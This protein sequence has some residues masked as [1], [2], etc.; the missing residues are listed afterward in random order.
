MN[1]IDRLT[2]ILL[3]LQGGKRSASQIARRFEISR[4][5][6]Q[7]DVQALSEM[8]IPVIADFGS[9]GGY[10]LPPD[11]ALPP[12]ALTLHEALLLRLALSGISQLGETLLKQE[13]ASLLDKIETLLPRAQTPS[14]EQL[15]EAISLHE[16]AR[17]YPTPFLDLLL[18]SAAR[19]QWVRVSYRSERGLSNQTLLPVKLRHSNGLWYCDAY[20]FERHE[21]RIY[22]VDRFQAVSPAPQ[23]NLP[24]EFPESSPISNGDPSLPEVQVQLTS[25]G[26]SL[27]EGNS[28]LSPQ[29]ITGPEE[30]WLKVRLRPQEYPWLIRVILGLGLEAKVMGPPE[31]QKLLKDEIQAISR[32]FLQ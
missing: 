15:Q 2:A 3:Y 13:R 19:R 25:R 24:Q 23:L 5:T 6:A 1:R 28:Y 22:R 14:L 4:R 26:V 20:S 10:S 31:L 27:L 9:K 8:G 18:E 21:N 29:I 16:P 12:L 7:R 32:H 11:F 17:D 30:S